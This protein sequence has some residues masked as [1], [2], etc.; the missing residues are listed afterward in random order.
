MSRFMSLF[1]NNNNSLLLKYFLNPQ[2][3]KHN[4]FILFFI[5]T[6]SWLLRQT[7]QFNLSQKC[8][9]IIKN[10]VVS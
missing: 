4:N 5:L 9:T 1:K 3:F 2:L 10:F 7:K 6:I 8:I